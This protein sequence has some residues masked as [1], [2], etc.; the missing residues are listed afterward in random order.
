MESVVDASAVVP[1]SEDQALYNEL[2]RTCVTPA[3]TTPAQSV[4]LGGCRITAAGE[5]ELPAAVLVAPWPA[6]QAHSWARF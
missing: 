4:V 3:E 2:L 6:T 5:N 1:E